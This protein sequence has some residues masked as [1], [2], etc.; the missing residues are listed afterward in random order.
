[1]EYWEGFTCPICGEGFTLK[2]WDKRHN[3][4]NGEEYHDTCCPECKDGTAD[5]EDEEEHPVDCTCEECAEVLR[6]AG[7]ELMDDEVLYSAEYDW[8]DDDDEDTGLHQC[9][10]EDNVGRLG[11]CEY[12]GGQI[13]PF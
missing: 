4:R 11:K 9:L 2:Q 5:D 13:I 1:M 3:G 7:Y 8:A 12:C 10:C 6:N